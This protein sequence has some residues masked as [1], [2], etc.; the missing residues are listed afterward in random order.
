M[1]IKM[2]NPMKRVTME[3][4]PRLMRGNGR[5]MT[6]SNP[7]TMAILTNTYKKNVK[8]ILPASRRLNIS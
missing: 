2:P 6:G 7:D 4:P 1:D 8:I 5:P 3:V